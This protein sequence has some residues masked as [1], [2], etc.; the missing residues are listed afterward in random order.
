MCH[1]EDRMGGFWNGRLTTSYAE[2]LESGSLSV[3]VKR[4]SGLHNYV[5]EGLHS[6]CVTV[7]YVSTV[8]FV[9]VKIAHVYIGPF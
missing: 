7:T 6:I 1:R 5:F 8:P 4:E 9:L 3:H 2:K